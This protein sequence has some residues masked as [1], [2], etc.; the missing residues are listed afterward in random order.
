MTTTVLMGFPRIPFSAHAELVASRGDVMAVVDT[1]RGL[2]H[3]LFVTSSMP[4]GGF[5]GGPVISEY[6]F[7][8]GV[9][10]ET[11]FVD[12]KEPE[13]GFGTAISPQPLWDLLFEHR[14]FPASN[15]EI[16]YLLRFAYGLDAS[17]FSLTDEQQRRVD[18]IEARGADGLPQA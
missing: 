3:P 4:R 8:L 13:L 10:T 2:R 7:L 14:L 17:A 9:L 5:S 12:D 16:A 15:L 11:L 6:D 1:Y 18:D